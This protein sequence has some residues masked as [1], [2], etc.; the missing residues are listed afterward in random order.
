[1]RTQRHGGLLALD[2]SLSKLAGSLVSVAPTQGE[3]ILASEDSCR[4]EGLGGLSGWLEGPREASGTRVYTV[5]ASHRPGSVSPW[6]R[7][8]QPPASWGRRGA[9]SLGKGRTRWF[10]LTLLAVSAL[11]WRLHHLPGLVVPGPQGASV[12]PETRACPGPWGASR[13]F[14]LW[15]GLS[16]SSPQGEAFLDGSTGTRGWDGAG[17]GSSAVHTWCR[18]PPPG[19]PPGG[20]WLRTSWGDGPRFRLSRGDKTFLMATSTGPALSGC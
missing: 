11:G 15:G 16:L 1:M 17:A 3:A 8:R 2:S 18:F 6:G 9:M 12:N 5:A 13:C 19:R 4:S 7:H 10:S 20:L 14:S